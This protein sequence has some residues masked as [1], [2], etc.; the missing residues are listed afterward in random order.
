MAPKADTEP[1]IAE[2]V[3]ALPKIAAALDPKQQP[4][5]GSWVALT[6]HSPRD[7]ASRESTVL[8]R[9]YFTWRH[10]APLEPL[11]ES[12][13]MELTRIEGT[14][15][16]KVPV[17]LFELTPLGDHDWHVGYYFGAPLRMWI[18]ERAGDRVQGYGLSYIARPDGDGWVLEDGDILA[19]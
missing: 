9:A 18:G 13:Y 15:V 16:I 12:R 2:A 7:E 4:V 11:E 17:W 14:D 19:G 3:S 5:G 6:V 8:H 1:I 10:D